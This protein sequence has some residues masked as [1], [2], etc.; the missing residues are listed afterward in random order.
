MYTIQQ[1][2]YLL[3]NWRSMIEERH[4]LGYL[5]KKNAGALFGAMKLLTREE[6][7]ILATKYYTSDKSLYAKTYKPM[8]DEDM[9][10]KLSMTK[11][12]CVKSRR[13]I[14]V[15][16]NRIMNERSEENG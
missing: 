11:K 3:R 12:G 14:E 1:T 9:A 6:V 8:I 15:K 13:L 4:D 16:L 2:R 10:K 5:G 7:Q